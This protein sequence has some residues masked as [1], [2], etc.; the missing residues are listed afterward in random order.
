M[1]F[2]AESVRPATFD[3]AIAASYIITV[4]FFFYSSA[5]LQNRF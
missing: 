2:A 1:L 3:I 4:M 5:L